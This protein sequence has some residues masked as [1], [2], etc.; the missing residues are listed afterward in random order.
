MTPNLHICV[1][2]IKEEERVVVWN[3]SDTSASPATIKTNRV[4]A[5]SGSDS[6]STL[7]LFEDFWSKVQ[8]GTSYVIRGYGLLGET[9]PYHIRLTRQTQFFRGS[10]ITVSSD[11][12]DEAERVLNPPS[13][14]VDVWESTQ[15]GGL[16]TVAGVV[17]ECSPVKKIR[18]GR[19]HVPVR[20]IRIKQDEFTV[21]VCLWREVSITDV[22]LGD[23]VTISHL[24][25]ETTMYGRQLTTEPLNVDLILEGKTVQQIKLSSQ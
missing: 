16:L 15:K 3:I 5:I 17:V 10:K 13:Q 4:A 6:V 7:T 2:K 11:L 9:P 25:A 14:V 18:S 24:K 22:S 1:L 21:R 8:E 20:N 23:V 19:E 12:K